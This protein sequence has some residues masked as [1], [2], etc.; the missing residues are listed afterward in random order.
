[1]SWEDTVK[2]TFKP[3]KLFHAAM[4]LIGAV[5]WLAATLGPLR[6]ADPIRIGFSVSL[7]GGLASSGK[8][9][10]LSKQIWEKELND[11]GGLLGRPVK[12]VYYDDQTNASTAPG[13]YAK[14]LDV[15]KVD[16]V[17]GAPTKLIG[18]A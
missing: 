5:S 17:M 8:A 4:T 12:L 1:M 11:K 13:I 14:L 9:H 6:A 2:L 7:T 16:L 10:L 3:A 18:P 15:A